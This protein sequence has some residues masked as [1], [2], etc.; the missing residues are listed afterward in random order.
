LT[1][2]RR[3]RRKKKGDFHGKWI[4]GQEEGGGGEE[5]EKSLSRKRCK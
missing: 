2:G 4:E 5:E 3:W 1:L